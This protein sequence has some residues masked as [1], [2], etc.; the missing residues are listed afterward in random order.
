MWQKNGQ[1]FENPLRFR[2]MV[3]WN[4][5]DAQLRGAGYAFAPDPAS[6][7]PATCSRYQLVKILE[8]RHPELLARFRSEYER[9]E[10][11]RFFWNTVNELDRNNADFRAVQAQLGIDDATVAGIFGA[12]VSGD[13]KKDE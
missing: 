9:N 11:L 2:G 1:K 4:P 10:N 3:V 6:E 5:T 8:T 12:A 7:A 13:E